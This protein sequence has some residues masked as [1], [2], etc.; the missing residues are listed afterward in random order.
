[1]EVTLREMQQAERDE[2][3]AEAV[4]AEAESAAGEYRKRLVALHERMDD[5]VLQVG[6][7]QEELEDSGVAAALAELNELWI[8]LHAVDRRFR[9]LPAA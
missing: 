5:L 2:A 7:V 3:R 6:V 9:D 1:M 4:T 8:I